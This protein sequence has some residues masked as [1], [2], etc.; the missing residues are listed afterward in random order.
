MIW[1]AY[2]QLP[3]AA[4]RSFE[5]YE[6]LLNEAAGNVSMFSDPWQSSDTCALPLAGY[7]LGL[8]R[9]DQVGRH[10]CAR[11][12]LPNAAKLKS[13]ALS[14][15]LTRCWRSLETLETARMWGRV[16]FLPRRL[17]NIHAADTDLWKTR[18]SDQDCKCFKRAVFD[19]F[20][21]LHNI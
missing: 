17:G 9:L 5:S 19:H 11:C 14:R 2:Q 15:A 13:H 20:K 8:S 6:P 10:Q 7:K 16:E 3:V 1:V 4:L 18:T 12:N 21:V